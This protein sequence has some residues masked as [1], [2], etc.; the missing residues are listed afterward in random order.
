MKEEALNRTMWRHR[1]GGGFGPVVRQN[2]GW[3]T[4]DILILINSLYFSRFC[5][6]QLPVR[7]ERKRPSLSPV[8]YYCDV[9]CLM[10]LNSV[11]LAVY[12]RFVQDILIPR[13]ILKLTLLI[14]SKIV[15]LPLLKFPECWCRSKDMPA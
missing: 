12:F 14:S 13:V 5:G 1:F 11:L 7:L 15:P 2:T 3:I 9:S 8:C 10:W 4:N 6:L